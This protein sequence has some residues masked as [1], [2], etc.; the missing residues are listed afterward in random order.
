MNACAGSFF[1]EFE[2]LGEAEEPCGS[3]VIPPPP[4][5]AIQPTK[6]SRLPAT[7]SI[8]R[9]LN[10]VFISSKAIVSFVLSI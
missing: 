7:R 3:A 8:S 6:L 9:R 10:A 2:I 5:L 4:P 1:S